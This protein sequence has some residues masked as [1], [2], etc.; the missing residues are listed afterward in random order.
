MVARLDRPVAEPE[1][2]NA[3]QLIYPIARSGAVIGDRQGAIGVSRYRVI[4]TGAGEHGGVRSAA[5][6]ESV[7]SAGAREDVVA[8][9]S[10]E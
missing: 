8:G 6:V 9:V 10:L 5:A 3:G 2:L 7:V 4:R 1:R